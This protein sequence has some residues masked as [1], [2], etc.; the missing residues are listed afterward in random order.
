MS[1]RPHS[2]HSSF[3]GSPGPPPIP[4]AP[5]IN[6]PSDR[7]VKTE[8][9]WNRPH[10]LSYFHSDVDFFFFLVVVSGLS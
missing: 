4:V 8:F 6:D 7:T 1:A 2:H 3:L 10:F 9:L 5:P